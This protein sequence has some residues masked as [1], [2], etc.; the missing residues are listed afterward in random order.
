MIK[1]LKISKNAFKVISIKHFRFS[2]NLTHK[3]LGTS[4]HGKLQNTL[5]A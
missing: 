4:S 2:K 1:A 5:Y 3:M